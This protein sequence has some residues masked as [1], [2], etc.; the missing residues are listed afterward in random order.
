MCIRDRKYPVSGRKKTWSNWQICK[1]DCRKWEIC[2][3]LVSAKRNSGT[4]NTWQ[5]NISWDTNKDNKVLQLSAGTIEKKS[6]WPIDTMRNQTIISEWWKGFVSVF[7]SLSLPLSNFDC[8]VIVK[9]NFYAYME[10]LKITEHFGRLKL[11]FQYIC[12]C[13]YLT[14]A[15]L[16]GL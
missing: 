5:K 7:F 12:I 8:M 15:P 1:E 6:E 11:R 10:L 3:I 4:W 14:W 16:Y 9:R 2:C 13:K